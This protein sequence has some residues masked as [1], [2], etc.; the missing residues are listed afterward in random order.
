[1]A[2]L[3][4]AP[5]GRARAGRVV[6]DHTEP[7]LE[8]E[9]DGLFAGELPI[10]YEVVDRFALGFEAAAGEIVISWDRKNGNRTAFGRGGVAGGGDLR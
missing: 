7:S 4:S 1:M 8:V 6:G 9:H 3:R 2:A 5:V 10:R